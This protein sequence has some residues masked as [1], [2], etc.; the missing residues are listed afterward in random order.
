MLFH[1][2]RAFQD[3]TGYQYDRLVGRTAGEIMLWDTAASRRRL[4]EQ[5]KNTGSISIVDAE[6]QTAGG[7]L[8][9]CLFLPCPSIWQATPT[10]SWSSRT[11]PSGVNRKSNLSPRTR[12]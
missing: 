6:V 3:M 1:A 7:G 4:E 12:R 2:N 5:V 10:F 11:L 9:D 8:F